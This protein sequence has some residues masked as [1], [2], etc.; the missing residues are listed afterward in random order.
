VGEQVV[1]MPLTQQALA[2]LRVQAGV[3]QTPCP[4]SRQQAPPLQQVG[5][6]ATPLIGV[7]VPVA[8]V[9]FALVQTE[10][11]PSALRQSPSLAHA[12]GGTQKPATQPLTPVQH[13]PPLQGTPVQVPRK[14]SRQVPGGQSMQLPPMHRCVDEQQLLPH[15]TPLQTPLAGSTQLPAGQLTHCPPLH[16]WPGEQQVLPQIVPV[17]PLPL[18]SQH[19]PAGQLWQM[20]LPPTLVQHSPGLQS[21]WLAPLPPLQKLQAVAA[22]P[23]A[24]QGMPAPQQVVFWQGAEPLGQTQRM[25]TQTEPPGQGLGHWH[26]PPAPHTDP[27]GQGGL[28]PVPGGGFTTG[29][30]TGMSSKAAFGGG[31]TGAGAGFGGGT[32][33]AVGPGTG[34]PLLQPPPGPTGLPQPPQLPASLRMSTQLPP[35]GTRPG[36]QGAAAR[37]PRGSTDAAMAPASTPPS[38]RSTARRER[39]APSERDRR[40]KGCS[41]RPGC[42]GCAT[43]LYSR[44]YWAA[45]ATCTRGMSTTALPA[46]L[47]T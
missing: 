31:T 14:G 33:G 17:Q 41:G 34:T 20:A 13:C 8:S 30:G 9:G 26:W 39:A 22:Q 6:Q 15:R 43:N 4:A 11:A 42:S 29:G 46:P 40:S 12:P 45:G 3:S 23:S 25:P 1:H 5:P 36:A 24:Q 37:T 16:C 10:H 44:C 21:D 27:V 28:Q 7:Q 32:T 2:P 47:V 19:V 38:W 35:Q 18:G